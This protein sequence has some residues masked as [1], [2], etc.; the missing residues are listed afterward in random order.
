MQPNIW[1]NSFRASKREIHTKLKETPFFL[2]E[3][4]LQKDKNYKT[5]PRQ[6]Q[7]SKGNKTTTHILIYECVRE[8]KC[9]WYKHRK[10][11][12]CIY[13]WFNATLMI[14]PKSSNCE[15]FQWVKT[16]G[17]DWHICTQHSDNVHLNHLQSLSKPIYRKIMWKYT[18]FFLK[19][20]MHTNT[21]TE[22]ACLHFES[23]ESKTKQNKIETLQNNHDQVSSMWKLN[24]WIRLH[25]PIS[26]KIRAVFISRCCF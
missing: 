23:K 21:C 20:Q 1:A 5:K 16:R 13:H 19:T 9:R 22:R 11:I 10:H 14:A 8:S 17:K 12:A 15:Q 26:W 2:S 7:R 3:E 25:I 6:K 18:Y 24:I 4:K